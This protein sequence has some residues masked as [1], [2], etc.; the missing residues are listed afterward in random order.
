MHHRSATA[1]SKPWLLRL[2]DWF[3]SEQQRDDSPHELRRRRILVGIPMAL[4]S[5]G[6]PLLAVLWALRA[7]PNSTRASLAVM[8]VNIGA[9]ATIR[10]GWNTKLTAFVLCA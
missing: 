5:L 3:L 2:I 9:L 7:D 1:A 10:L 8:F 4:V 6:G